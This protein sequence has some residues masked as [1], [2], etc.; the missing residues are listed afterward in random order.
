MRE[1]THYEKELSEWLKMTIQPGK[2]I[3]AA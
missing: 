1:M 2:M 3:A